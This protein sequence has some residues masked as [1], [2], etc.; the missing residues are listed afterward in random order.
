MRYAS[1]TLRVYRDGKLWTAE[2]PELGVASCGATPLTAIRHAQE[3]CALHLEGLIE[4]FGLHK[5][6]EKYG[7]AITDAVGEE[8]VSV[9][10]PL[11]RDAFLLT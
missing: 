5:A 9:L 10:V 1:L 2:S 8:R 11:P 3:A 7:L 4:A 6:A